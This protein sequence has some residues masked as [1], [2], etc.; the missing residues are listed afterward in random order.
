MKKLLF[1]AGVLALA[2]SCTND[3]LESVSVQQQLGKG[4]TFEAVN[5]DPASTKGEFIEENGTH[6]PLWYAEQDR[7]KIYSTLTANDVYSATG[8]NGTAD[9][10][11]DKSAQ[12]KATTSGR[13][14]YFTGIDDNSILEFAAGSTALTPSRFFALYPLTMAVTAVDATNKNL[15]TVS[16]PALNKQKQKNLAGQ[17]AFDAIARYSISSAYPTNSYDAVGEKAN[18]NFKRVVPFLVFSTNGVDEYVDEKVPANDIFGKLK[19]IEVTTAV[20][21]TDG[22]YDETTG[23]DIIY[24][25]TGA[26]FQVDTKAASEDKEVVAWTPG[27]G[28]K[29][30]TLTI[31]ESN[32]LYWNDDAYAYMAIAPIKRT[33]AEALKVV[34][35]FDNIEFTEYTPATTSAWTAPNYYSVPTLDID[36]YDYLVA[37][38]G[39]GNTEYYLI[40][41]KG[42]F[43]A[44]FSADDEVIWPIGSTATVAPDK[45]TK[46]IVNMDLTD[47]QLQKI[48]TLFT[49]V[50]DYRLTEETSIPTNAMSN[51]AAKLKK[52]EMP[53]VTTIDPDFL[54]TTGTV[55]FGNQLRDL[56]MASYDFPEE[57]INAKF[58]NTDT[59]GS[60]E[61]LNIS[62]IADMTGTF[63]VSRTID[64]SGYGA[65]K[66]VTMQNG[67][68]LSPNAFKNCNLLETITGTVALTDKAIATS[69]F[70]G[71]TAL[72][73]VNVSGTDIPEAAFRN[74]GIE[75]ILVNGQAI[76]PTSIGADAFNKAAALKYMNL[77][78]ATTIGARAFR[79]SGIVGTS[80]TDKVIVVGVTAAEDEIFR[81]TAVEY[82][83]FSNATKING[84][85]LRSVRT[86]KQIKFGKSFEFGN[87]E[88]GSDAVKE[89][90]GLGTDD[91]DLFLVEEMKNGN[92]WLP[93]SNTLRVPTV[94]ADGKVGTPYDIL[95]NVIKVDDG[96]FGN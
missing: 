87:F 11:E 61:T 77:S 45:F 82:V 16:L 28:V 41:N 50:T 55:A 25:N 89:I 29:T 26:T 73:K 92:Y 52:L 8:V 85:I 46:V 95:F 63:N 80:K 24:A 88:E 13:R 31:G 91:V 69:A 93:N 39:M 20:P 5:S 1:C 66:S 84:S 51:M 76:V 4:I 40:V 96:S 75:E 67:A 56:N 36:E 72:K 18:L 42:N 71:T 23:S 90:F 70:E 43:D 81:N 6:Y 32:G 83:Y 15:L 62:G 30:A 37:N 44:I 57:D 94:K 54:G 27:T 3:E 21:Q 35:T 12:Y 68:Q 53:K 79:D 60:L 34:Y 48:N 7:I 58:F 59:Q 78:K 22:T 64:F 86:L 65:L 17:G 33:K 10:D 47:A 74:S 19:T 38:K 14:G 2:A 9:W 49:N